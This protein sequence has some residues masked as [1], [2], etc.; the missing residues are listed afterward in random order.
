MSKQGKKKIISLILTLSIITMLILSGPVSAVQVKI[1][2]ISDTTPNESTDMTF[3]VQVDI[4]SGER[5][6]VQNL[7]L[8]LT[9]TGGLDNYTCI[10]NPAG[11]N[12]TACTGITITKLNSV[13]YS[14]S[15]SLWG[16]GYGYDYANGVT[17]YS[18]TSFSSTGSETWNGYGYGY[19]YGYTSGYAYNSANYAELAY[20]ITWTTP[21]VTSNTA[22]TADFEALVSD[23]TT[24]RTYKTSSSSTITVQNVAATTNTTDTDS[25]SSSSTTTPS[26]TTTPT[27]VSKKWNTIIAGEETTMNIANDAIPLLAIVFTTLNNYDNV[28]LEVSTT[29]LPVN[30]PSPSGT[31]YQILDID[32]SNLPEAGIDEAKIKF[33]IPLIW[34]EDNDLDPFTVRLMRYNNGWQELETTITNEDST[35]IY[36][37]S[38]TPGFSYFVITAEK[39]IES[40]ETTTEETTAETTTEETTAEETQEE[41]PKSSLAWLWWTLA[42]VVIAAAIT[43]Y[44]TKSKRPKKKK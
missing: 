10:F 35:Y 11:T 20:N 16:Y 42:I 18:N 2:N 44:L 5:I 34:F 36:F 22:Y 29:T 13:G 31:I 7:T 41:D 21:S 38:I 1:T 27:K 28:E 25:S 32:S 8:T 26:I 33:K 15:S 4:E 30:I 40:A 3:L 43:I 14:N 19:G 37:E 6:P 12:I 23:G 39:K 24:K 17:N 9:N